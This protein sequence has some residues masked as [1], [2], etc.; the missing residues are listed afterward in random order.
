MIFDSFK[1]FFMNEDELID[2]FN[3]KVN[4][5][6][7]I[8][9]MDYLINQMNYIKKNN[10]L[11][12]YDDLSIEFN[13]ILDEENF[14][15]LLKFPVYASSNNIL[16]THI[17]FYFEKISFVDIDCFN[18]VLFLIYI[19]YFRFNNILDVNNII[20]KCLGSDFIQYLSM[21][22]DEYKTNENEPLYFEDF[23]RKLKRVKYDNKKVKDLDY[24]IK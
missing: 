5:Y 16:N 23:L 1:E 20:R 12:D 7:N 15:I 13:Q 11:K 2:F 8:K 24:S 19:N 6:V 4:N 14:L 9:G 22:V 3:E 18:A 21:H 10:L 17:P